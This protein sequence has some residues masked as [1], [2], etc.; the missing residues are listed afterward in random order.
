MVKCKTKQPVSIA[1]VT[2]TYNASRD[3]PSLIQSLRDQTD[4]DF[5]W[6]VADGASNDGTLGLLQSIGD[7][8]LA[9]SSQADFGIYDALNRAIHMTSADYYIIAGADDFFDSHAISHFRKAIVE[10]NA[11]IVTADVMYCKRRI[12]LKKG[13]AWLFGHSALITAHSLGTAFRKGL[14]YKYGF[15]SR[16]LPIAADQLFVMQACEAGASRYKADFVVGEVGSD[17][18]SSLDRVG[19]ATEVYRAQLTLGRSKIV[20]LLLLML[21][22]LR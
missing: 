18:V 9:L 10:S 2:A 5:E 16:K 19:N 11:D 12:G 6:V 21:R 14:H 17:V 7:L 20:Q 8:N 15:Y 1:V 4:K 13:P 3:L 22:L